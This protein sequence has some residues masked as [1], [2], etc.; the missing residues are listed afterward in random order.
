MTTVRQ[1][2]NEKG[3][4]VWSIHPDNSVFEAIKELAGKNVGAL[5]VVEDDKLVGMFTERDY[6][7]NVFLEGKSSPKTS[8]RE[9]MKTHI[10]CARPEQT[11][12]ECMAVITE[13]R[14]RH[15]PVLDEQKLVGI[16]SIGDMVKNII[17]DQKFT[18]EQLEHYI[19]D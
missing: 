9:V 16:V 12:E 19:R 3:H 15:L 2:L 4:D 1:I 11:V 7:R 10:V 5:A 14:V 6:T 17:A 13:K 8:V 18:I